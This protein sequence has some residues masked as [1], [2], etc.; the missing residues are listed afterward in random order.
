MGSGRLIS[1]RH[2]ATLAAWRQHIDCEATVTYMLAND[3]WPKA[4]FVRRPHFEDDPL[5]A[6]RGIIMGTVMSL[7]VFW[8]PLAIALAR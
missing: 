4:D 8:M 5:A 3:V 1:S 6:I 2:R 7:L